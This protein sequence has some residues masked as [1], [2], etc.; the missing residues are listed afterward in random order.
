MIIKWIG[1]FFKVIGILLVV[2]I[3]FYFVSW[4]ITTDP[5]ESSYRF[6]EIDPNA[7]ISKE[8]ALEDLNDYYHAI[9]TAHPKPYRY[10]SKLEF[11]RVKDSLSNIVRNHPNDSVRK[12]DLYFLLRSLAAQTKDTHTIIFMS[13]NRDIRYFPYGI[14]ILNQNIYV[15][16]SDSTSQ[17]LPVGTEITS[18]NGIKTN[19]ILASL[20]SF[21]STAL[22]HT[23]NNKIARNFSFY[24]N[25]YYNIKDAVQLQVK[26]Q[27]KDTILTAKLIDHKA[28]F[29]RKRKS[30]SKYQFSNLAMS[31]NSVP[32]IDL[33]DCSNIDLNEFKKEIDL[34]FEKHHEEDFIIIDVRDNAGGSEEYGRYILAYLT[35][36]RIKT[37]EN[38]IW[39][40]SDVARLQ[41]LQKKNR[42]FYNMKVPSVL[43]SL[44]IHKLHQYGSYIEDKLSM[45]NGEIRNSGP[46]Y[47]E[48]HNTNYRFK[49][50][51]IMLINHGTASAAQDIAA[52]FKKNELGTLIGSETKNSMSFGGNIW[53]DLELKNSGIRYYMPMTYGVMDLADT[54]A[55]VQPDIKVDYSFKE[56]NG[57]VD[58]E[59]KIVKEYVNKI[60][61][62]PAGNNV[63]SK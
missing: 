49:G 7:T 12:V 21:E 17:Q 29:R 39:K 2:L 10:V 54:V 16:G 9:A 15:V 44:P 37:Y 62:M 8:K 6:N 14:R 35:D 20:S 55:G 57:K 47:F 32:V 51:A 53:V 25:Y 13:Q 19:K 59:I 1:S 38:Y 30:E 4:S 46:S 48:A 26:S 58:K 40:M 61:K 52:I 23:K 22:E 31:D 45:S 24:L 42:S 43:W 28:S 60:K 3:V 27:G 11:K 63:Y 36:K 18:I 33:N 56:Y 41:I 34:F 50:H 5:S